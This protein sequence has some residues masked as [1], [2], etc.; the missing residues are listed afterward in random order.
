SDGRRGNK[1]LPCGERRC[2]LKIGRTFSSPR[3]GLARKNRPPCS[4]A[5][6]KRL[7]VTTV[8]CPWITL[9]GQ[10]DVV[11]RQGGLCG[12]RRDNVVELGKLHAATEIPLL[13]KPVQELGHPPGEALGF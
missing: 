13:G 1:S 11:L 9:Q 12:L 2:R 4:V 6:R 3:R 8:L 5:A 10:A 7:Y